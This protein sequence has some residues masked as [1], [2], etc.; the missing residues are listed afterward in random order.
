MTYVSDKDL[1]FLKSG[2]TEKRSF[3]S[4]KL[5]FPHESFI[6]VYDYEQPVNQFKKT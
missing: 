1:E 3:S 6:I 5:A 2:L 4:K